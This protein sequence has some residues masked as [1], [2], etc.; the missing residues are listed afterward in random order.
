MKPRSAQQRAF[1][2]ALFLLGTTLS[3]S[4][5]SV[6]GSS[7]AAKPAQPEQTGMV[8]Y[9]I[10]DIPE[11]YEIRAEALEE[12]ELSYSK[13]PMDAITSA[14]LAQGRNAKYGISSGQIVSQHD[15]AP[16]HI[17]HT[18]NVSLSDSAYDQISRVAADSGRTESE[19]VSSWIE[20][21]LNA[22]STNNE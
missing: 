14:T 13:I 11:G 19:L 4:S 9:A 20:E 15:L 16:Q 21:K 6:I 17:G 2:A 18:V 8:V 10:Q 5:C 22:E 12:R 3:V 1:L 7:H